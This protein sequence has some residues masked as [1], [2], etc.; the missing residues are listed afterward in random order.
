MKRIIT[1]LLCTVL[2][3]CL[4]AAGVNAEG[5]KKISILVVGNSITQH[6]PSESLGWFWN[7]G[8]AASSL[9]DDYYHEMQKLLAEEFPDYE[10]EWN[11]AGAYNFERS[12]TVNTDTDY[13]NAFNTSFGN[14]MKKVNPDI[15]TF[16][17]GDNIKNCTE[18]SYTYALTKAVEYCR[19]YNPNVALILSEN[20]YGSSG[21]RRCVAVRNVAKD[22]KVPY[23]S[24]YPLCIPENRAFGLFEHSGVEGHP[25]DKGMEEI[26]K[27]FYSE[28]RKVILAKEGRGDVTV[29]VDGSYVD[30][31]VPPTIIDGR[32]LV[33]VRAIFEALGATVEWDDT[34]KTVSSRLGG[35]VIT[36]PV[37]SQTMKKNDTDITLDVPAMI[38]DGRTLVPVRAI[39]EAYNCTVNWLAETRCVDIYSPELVFDFS[40][41]VSGAI[42]TLADAENL[43]GGYDIFATGVEKLQFVPNPKDE[44]DTVF[45]LESNVTDGPSWTYFWCEATNVMKPGQRYLTSFDIMFDKTADGELPEKV[46]GGIC[47]QF[48][49]SAVDNN[50]S[51]HGVCTYSAAPGEWIHIDHIYTVPETMSGDMAAKFGIYVNPHNGE[52]AMSYYLDDVSVVPYEGDLADG[53]V[54]EEIKKAASS[55]AVFNIDTA[56]GT[57]VDLTALKPDCTESSV[58]G[59]SLIMKSAAEKPDP[60]VLV[61][62]LSVDASK[63]TVIAVKFTA[64]SVEGNTPF[65]I[66]FSTD[67]EKDLSESKS[68]KLDYSSCKKLGDGS[69]LGYFVMTTNDQWKGTVTSIRLDPANANGNWKIEKVVLVE[70]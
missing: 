11:V 59:S 31:D 2:A 8:M 7:W 60:K 62:N 4:L 64:D 27:T 56:K 14:T 16:Q 22:L 45:Y 3:A 49:D 20:F 18:E 42:I 10:A 57:V 6:A 44:S 19:E 40:N 67:T 50:V 29:K 17:W 65:Q 23:V 47:F 12:V 36:L 48:A 53:R 38:I 24:L 26:A 21:D 32:T 66:Y 37:G 13:T 69:L 9:E 15:I 33:P 52:K 30:F 39:S 41:E 58:E 43:T 34:T 54:T 68:V 35:T 46:S 28:V 61:P 51:D 63:V 25:G 5:E 1:I 70:D 55:A